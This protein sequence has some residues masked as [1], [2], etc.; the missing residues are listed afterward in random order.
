MSS[1]DR[2]LA[3]YRGEA[4]DRV[5]VWLREGFPPFGEL[6][7]ADDF[8]CGWQADAAYRELYEELAP[9]VD[10]MTRWT[11]QGTNRLLMVP[12]CFIDVEVLENSPE[13]R[14]RKHVV[15]TPR[16]DLFGVR[17]ERR[18]VNTGWV[19]KPLVESREELAMLAE[20][21][22]EIDEAAVAASVASYREAE[23]R[24]GGRALPLTS[25]SSAMVCISGCMSL[26]LFLELSFTDRQWM[27]ELCEEVLRRQMATYAEIFSPGMR[28]AVIIGG[29]EQCTPPLMSPESYDRLVVPYETRLIEF[30][31]GM[32]LPVQIHCHGRVGHALKCMLAEGADATD[33]V[34]PPPA[35]DVT[36]EQAREIVGDRLT[37]VGNLEWDELESAEPRQIR[38]HVRRVLALGNRRLILAASAGPISAVTP[39]LAANY[40]AWVEAA[41]E[42]GR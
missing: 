3:A 32:N 9:R 26:E 22:F 16:G 30:L 1:A 38:E 33:P 5:P 23:A 19:L 37:L 10:W 41:E 35:G 20:V 15:H 29:S 39:R 28:T 18:G 11:I 17:E 6:A 27:A 8:S 25:T 34:E 42:F 12:R 7:G 36:Y 14:R 24:C 40:R 13:R 4:V 2:L 21:P 31:H